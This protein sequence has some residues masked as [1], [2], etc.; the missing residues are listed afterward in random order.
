MK[1]LD[2][3]PPVAWLQHW[4]QKRG[5]SV[6][7]RQPVNRVVTEYTWS[8]A[9]DKTRKLAA[10]LKGLGLERG[11]RVSIIAKNSAEWILADLAIQAAGLVSAPV[12]P[13][14]SKDTISYVLDH[15]AAK[16]VFIGHLDD[17]RTV[18]A[19]LPDGLPTIGFSNAA[20]ACD[21]SV[22][23]M[24]AANQPIENVVLGKADDLFTIVYTSGSTGVPKG[25]ELTYR[26]FHY[27]AA[28]PAA[29]I[30]LGPS[31]RMVS[32]LPLAHMFERTCIEHGAVYSGGSIWF[33]E[34][35]ETFADDLK[36]AQP[37]YFHSI[38]R[39]WMKFQAGILAKMPQQKLGRLLKLPILGNVV[40][41]KIK[42]QLGLQHAR[43]CVSGSAPISPA[44]LHWFADL[45]IPISEGWGMTETGGAS[46]VN[47]PFRRDKIGTIGRAFPG[48][49]IKISGE[50]EILIRGDSLFSG[51]H[52]NPEATAKDMGDDGWFH[53]GDRAEMDGEGY[54][55]ITGRVKEL[56]K[57]GKGK[58]VAPVPIESHLSVDEHIELVCVL[59]AGLP[60]P[61][62]VA[63][64]AAETTGGKSHEEIHISLTQTLA[65]TN[66]QVEK[67]EQL[68]RII[69]VKD[70]WTIEN[71]FLTPT[72]KIKRNHIEKQY[73][74]I[75]E[76]PSKDKVVFA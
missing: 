29:H 48:T 18:Q 40:R 34:S 32:Y 28:A 23:D 36:Q 45:G 15:S 50:G 8:Q 60:Q 35:L 16:A 26:N 66:E 38:P 63:V 4:A 9:W 70:E 73:E 56:F 69:V 22:P 68:D 67:H 7:M 33:I 62:A 1:I 24:I 27:G 19:A 37:T 59:G 47:Y 20:F 11:D 52:Q 75:L 14:A 76:H 55:K 42:T 39:L 74:P 6:F 53:T 10:A 12:Y 31:D 25:V 13:T 57:T 54:L 49:E 71:D 43:I 5:S 17:A 58:Y 64:L 41:K 3:Q 51:Y 65:R 44:I 46:T 61:V 21:H 2:Y 72:M 30:S